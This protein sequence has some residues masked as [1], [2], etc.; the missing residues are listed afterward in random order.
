MGGGIASSIAPRSGRTRADA[1]ALALHATAI[2]LGFGAAF[3]L[4]V[5]GGGR[6]LYAAMAAAARRSAPR[7]SR[8]GYS[9]GPCWCG[10][11][12]RSPR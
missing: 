7:S 1:D 3:T 9:P 8:G 2:A 12:I 4:G 10:C 11:S 6:W 5:L